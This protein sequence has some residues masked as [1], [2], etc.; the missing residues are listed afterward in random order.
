MGTILED[1]IQ[2]RDAPLRD[3]ILLLIHEEKEAG[4]NLA[5]IDVRES[6][7]RYPDMNYNERVALEEI[8]KKRIAKILDFVRC[9]L[10]IGA[11]PGLNVPENMSEH[12]AIVYRGVTRLVETYLAVIDVNGG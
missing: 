7:K 12:E 3:N 11:T 8:T 2:A 9:D 4:N 5:K 6:L 1:A 10:W